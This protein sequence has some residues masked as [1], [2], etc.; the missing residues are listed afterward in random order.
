MPGFKVQQHYT[1]CR[2]PLN[3]PALPD[4]AAVK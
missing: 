1:N 3:A 4:I 2:T